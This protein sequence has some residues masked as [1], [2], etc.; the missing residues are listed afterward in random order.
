VIVLRPVTKPDLPAILRW[1]NDPE[2]NH[3]LATQGT[4]LDRLDHWHAGIG[5]DHHAF[6]IIVDDVFVGYTQIDNVDTSNRK[7][8]IGVIIGDKSYWSRGICTVVA[9]AS[10]EIA[11]VKLGMHRAVAVASERNPASVRCFKRVGYIEEGRLRD[12]NLRNGEFFDLVV[13]SVL[14]HEWKPAGL[15]AIAEQTYS[16]AP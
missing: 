4:T 15:Q 3:D 11:F 16:L 13:M 12:A 5:S 14:E 2:V 7:C 9:R 6:A 8:D 10:T 1:R